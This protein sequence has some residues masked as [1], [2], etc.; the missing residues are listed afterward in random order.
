MWAEERPPLDTF[1]H[2]LLHRHLPALGDEGDVKTPGSI[3]CQTKL[4]HKNGTLNTKAMSLGVM[5][6][7]GLCL[8]RARIDFFIQSKRHQNGRGG[9]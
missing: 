7:C 8:L 2:H 4:F 5:R 1:R 6:F 9:E 3:V